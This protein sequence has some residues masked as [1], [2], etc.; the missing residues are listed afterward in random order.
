MSQ[1]LSNHPREIRITSDDRVILHPTNTNHRQPKEVEP[2][3]G[4]LRKLAWGGAL[5]AGAAA[6]GIG[7]WTLVQHFMEDRLPHGEIPIIKAPLEPYKIKP[8]N[9]NAL[10]IPHQDKTIYHKISGET[11]TEKVEHLLEEPEEPKAMAPHLPDAFIE[12]LAADAETDPFTEA[13]S[14]FI[15]DHRSPEPEQAAVSEEAPAVLPEPPSAPAHPPLETP[16]EP[17]NIADKILEELGE[18]PEQEPL[19]P[20]QASP[21]KNET[22]PTEEKNY[23]L[24]LASSRHKTLILNE[25]ERLSTHT[26]IKKMLQG[27]HLEVNTLASEKSQETLWRLT[28]GPMTQREAK[29][30]AARLKEENVTGLLKKK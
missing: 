3:K 11:P 4:L 12:G 16:E 29:E 20:A 22:I 9:P 1:N 13:P 28:L 10:E 25:K 26:R 2:S 18:S 19:T 23:F 24:Q 6:L 27:L 30:M 15:E 5:L 7:G 17:R 21:R 14:P 8:E